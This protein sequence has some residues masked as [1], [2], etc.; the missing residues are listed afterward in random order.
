MVV[1]LLDVDHGGIRYQVKQAGVVVVVVSRLDV[2]I[3]VRVRAL[4]SIIVI[5][6]WRTKAYTH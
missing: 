6:V 2:D 3:S 4:C 1:S 5:Q